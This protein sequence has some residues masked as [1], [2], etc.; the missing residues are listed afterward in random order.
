MKIQTS[1]LFALVSTMVWTSCTENENSHPDNEI[2]ERLEYS[3][4]YSIIRTELKS[5]DLDMRPILKRDTLFYD[6]INT[7]YIQK[8]DSTFITSSE[9]SIG[10]ETINDGSK[11]ENYYHTSTFTNTRIRFESTDSSL[12]IDGYA[13]QGSRIETR[14]TFKG[15]KI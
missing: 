5:F 2:L 11:G 13:Q 8:A 10:F 1:I 7:L 6:E 15:K 9:F 12:R 4:L 14:Y 3:G